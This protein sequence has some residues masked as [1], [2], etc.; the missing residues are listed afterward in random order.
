MRLKTLLNHM[1]LVLLVLSTQPMLVCAEELSSD[2]TLNLDDFP[3]SPLP[4][5][6]SLLEEQT[7]L[8]LNA[9]II[10]LL[11]LSEENPKK[12]LALLPKIEEISANFNAAE[13]YL[14]FAIKANIANTPGQEHKVINWLNQALALEK[15]IAMVQLQLPMFNKSYVLLSKYYA[16]T[17]Q[18]QQ[19]YDKKD[20]YMERFYQYRMSLKDQRIKKLNKK[21]DTDL[22]LKENKLLQSQHE[23]EAVQLQQTKQR[24]ITQQRNIILLIVA[25]LIIVFLLFRQLRIRSILRTLALTD[26]LTGLN[27]RKTLFEQGEQLIALAVEEQQPLSVILFDIDDFKS[28]ND[29]YGHQ[30]GDEVIK[31]IASLGNEIMRSRDVF[32]RLGGEEFAAVLPG[33]SL[34][35]AKAFAERLREKVESFQL[36][37]QGKQYTVTISAGIANLQQ[38]S[39]D[40]ES[41]LNAAD[42]AMYRAKN[43]G[44]NCVCCFE[45]KD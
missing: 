31:A 21:Y 29:N 42:Q 38:V 27:N 34:E 8:P 39:H 1:W 30:V 9:R 40:F 26:S 32:S 41:I 44:R 15:Q 7:E 12:A 19:A 5:R 25:T 35:Q 3:Q 36:S 18:F 20:E 2:A 4:E 24:N 13:K 23:F 37:H 11:K 33:T 16:L 6:I 14:M 10:A 45:L 17:G 43:S 28:I 22:K